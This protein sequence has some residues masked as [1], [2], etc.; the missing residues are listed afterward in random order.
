MGRSK[1]SMFISLANFA[2]ARALLLILFAALGLI[3]VRT[4][5]MIYPITWTTSVICYYVAW[6]MVRDKRPDKC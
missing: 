5:G 3:S 6:W 4:V 1:T 2:V